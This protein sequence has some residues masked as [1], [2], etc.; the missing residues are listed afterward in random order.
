M[1]DKSQSQYL[2]RARN[3]KLEIYAPTSDLLLFIL[4]FQGVTIAKDLIKYG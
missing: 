2:F 1:D 3:A 4:Q